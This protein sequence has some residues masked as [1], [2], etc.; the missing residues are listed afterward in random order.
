MSSKKRRNTLSANATNAVEEL[1]AAPHADPSQIDDADELNVRRQLAAMQAR[2]DESH[3]AL[4]AARLENE[5][6]RAAVLAPCPRCHFHPNWTVRVRTM[7]GQV[8]T[9]TCPDGPATLI[10]HVKQE[11]A[12]FDPKFIILQQLVLV[13]PCEASSSSSSSADPIDP[14]LGDDRTLASCGVSN[15]DLLDLLMVDIE[16]SAHSLEIIENIK[17]GGVHVED[18]GQGDFFDEDMPVQV[19]DGEEIWFH[20]D[21][22]IRD[23]NGAL[24]LTWALVNAVCLLR[25]S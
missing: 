5:R 22:P 10:A 20:E 15:G 17:H 24:A 21:M 8:H 25:Q 1:I 13:L 3:A 6:M 2:L 19:Y 7:A 12:Q 18:D 11:L 23:E 16:W 14:A 4:T 9:I